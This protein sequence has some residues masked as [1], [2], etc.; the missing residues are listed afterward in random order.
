MT[1]SESVPD[2]SCDVVAGNT[3]ASG[4]PLALKACSAGCTGKCVIG[5]LGGA[6]YLSPIAREEQALLAAS[7]VGQPASDDGYPLIRLACHARPAGDV[8]FVLCPT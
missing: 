1:Y 2:A 7:G 3:I 4:L 8:S 5:C 6:Q